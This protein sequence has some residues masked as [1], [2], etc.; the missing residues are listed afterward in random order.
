MVIQPVLSI[1]VP[2]D[3]TLVV[4]ADGETADAVVLIKNNGIL[5]L[6]LSILAVSVCWLLGFS[7]MAVGILRMLIR[8][9]AND[10]RVSGAAAAT[11]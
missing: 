11:G 2:I 1:D 7:L 6:V 9:L 5:P 10:A 4:D 3:G 8:L